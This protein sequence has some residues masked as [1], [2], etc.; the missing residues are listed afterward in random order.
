MSSLSLLNDSTWYVLI[1]MHW[2]NIKSALFT[3]TLLSF[4]NFISTKK[5]RCG[6]KLKM[7]VAI[8]HIYVQLYLLHRRASFKTYFGLHN[9]STCVH[10]WVLTIFLFGVWLCCTKVCEPFQSC[11]CVQFCN[12]TQSF[13]CVWLM[14]SWWV[15]GFP[16]SLLYLVTAPFMNT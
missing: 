8:A 15:D 5:F 13:P 2:I 1:C 9:C 4:P 12:F 14:G 7:L 16:L 11:G 3:W 10:S 6:N